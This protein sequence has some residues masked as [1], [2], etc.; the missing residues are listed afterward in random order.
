MEAVASRPFIHYTAT[1]T[2]AH[3]S[4]LPVLGFFFSLFFFSALF[5]VPCRASLFNSSLSRLARIPDRTRSDRETHL[6]HTSQN[7]SRPTACIFHGDRR[8]CVRLHGCV[9]HASFN[10]ASPPPREGERK[11]AR[12][13]TCTQ[14]RTPAWEYHTHVVLS[15]PPRRLGSGQ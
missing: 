10:Q 12:V 9:R 4:K 8:R 7:P 3:D 5:L 14:T 15:R 11:P 2:S 1:P 6:I 13:S